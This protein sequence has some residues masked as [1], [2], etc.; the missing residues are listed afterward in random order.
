VFSTWANEALRGGDSID[1]LP[2]LGHFQL[3]LDAAHRQHYLAFAAGSGITPLLSIIASTLAHEP[4]SRWAER[5]S[6]A[7]VDTAGQ[8]H[9]LSWRFNSWRYAGREPARGASALIRAL[10][11]HR[12]GRQ[13]RR[14]FSG[15]SP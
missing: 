15:A 4:A 5:V 8:L 12:P 6:L 10:D 11:R 13:N 1:V 3:P 7:G 2:P 9:E 14:M